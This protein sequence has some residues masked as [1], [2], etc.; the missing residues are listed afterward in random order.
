MERDTNNNLSV[1]KAQ[2]QSFSGPIAFFSQ[3]SDFVSF[4]KKV[5]RLVSALY[6]ITGFFGDNE[7]LKWK[8]RQIGSGLLSSSLS[9]QDGSTDKR[10]RASLSIRDTVLEITSLLS[11]AKQAGMVSDM[12]FNIINSQFTLLLESLFGSH[13]EVK[14]I[15]PKAGDLN[16][17]FF[18]TTASQSENQS[19]YHEREESSDKPVYRE[20][21]DIRE[22]DPKS[23]VL[24]QK[25]AD[26]RHFVHSTGLLDEVPED[27]HSRALSRLKGQPERNLPQA[28]KE[29][30]QAG[31][32]FKEFGV[33]AIKKNSRQ[34]III[35]LLK[36][37]K[38]IMIKD[39]SPLIDGCS[40]K[41]IQ[42]EL[43]AMVNQGI[44]RKEGEK[45]WSRYS[46]VKP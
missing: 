28:H 6:L 23:S 12:N 7:P 5:E 46:L 38:E 34:S 10:D 27:A 26:K 1:K 41:T 39:V 20:T 35:S 4:Y 31:P 16:E 18:H 36:R 9:L 13:Q 45:R 32:S 24:E 37:K 2:E 17:E 14:S 3:D 8:L 11:V 33:V 22:T 42:R 21:K 43:L 15:I 40:E 44:L 25:Q 29:R 19:D 30:K